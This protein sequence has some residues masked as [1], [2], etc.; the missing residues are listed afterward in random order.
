MSPPNPIPDPPRARL[1]PLVLATMASQALLVVLSPAIVAIGADLS[2]PVEAV[3]QAR[4]ITAVVAIGASAAIAARIDVFGVP[5]M[6]ALGAALAVGASAAIAAAP[7]LPV[8][9]AAHAIVGVAFAL[10]LSAA[11][12]GVAAFPLERRAW[13]IG[14]VVGANALAW[15]AVNPL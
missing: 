8:F 9:L 12:A 7:T 6:L 1:A 4:S 3:G 2:A 5:R 10:L 15:I 14:R 13:A 11:F